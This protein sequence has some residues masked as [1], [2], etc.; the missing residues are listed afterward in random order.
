M[1]IALFLGSTRKDRKSD[2]AALHLL[3]LFQQH[4][5]VHAEILDLD[6]AQLPIFTERW[7]ES[8]NPDPALVAFSAKLHTADALVFISPEYHGSYT[9]AFK[10]AIDHFWAEFQRKPIGVV[11][12]GS[13]RF[14]GINA[15]TQM[16]QLVL[17]LGGFPMP[18]KLLVPFVQKVYQDPGIPLDEQL[19]KD[20]ISFVNE[21]LWFA[22]ALVQAKHLAQVPRR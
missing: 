19:A 18:R 9:G 12:T 11:A 4:A 17:S 1:N 22:K 7:G 20:A 2:Q 21:F 6:E 8:Q 5:D 16:Q 3:Q 15:S 14:G 13:G 10:N